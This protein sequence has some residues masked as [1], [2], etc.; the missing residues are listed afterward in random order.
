MIKIL[1]QERWP[2]LADIFRKEFDAELPHPTAT[3]F[4][5]LDDDN[6][7]VG[8]LVVEFLARVGQ[9]YQT[10][11]STR[12]MLELVESQISPGNAVIAIAHEPRFER[13]CESW[14]MRPVEGQVYRRD[15]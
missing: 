10:G 2:E 3:I 6:Q 7:I 4:A 15:F 9:I 5:E 12:S 11:A 13:L 8:F 14:N 1:P